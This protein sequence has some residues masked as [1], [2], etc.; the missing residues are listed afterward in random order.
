MTSKQLKLNIK[1]HST[2]SI[3]YACTERSLMHEIKCNNMA[4]DALLI[5][6]LQDKRELETLQQQMDIIKNRIK[7]KQNLLRK[8]RRDVQKQINA[9]TN[10]L[11]LIKKEQNIVKLNKDMLSEQEEILKFQKTS[12]LNLK[13]IQI[14][15]EIIV[16]YIKEFIPYEI[17]YQL[18]DQKFK[19]LKLLNRMSAM[20]LNAII[21]KIRDN[22]IFFETVTTHEANIIVRQRRLGVLGYCICLTIKDA[23]VMVLALIY[24][25][26]KHCPKLALEWLQKLCIL[27]NPKKK[28]TT[29]KKNLITI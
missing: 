16:D 14:L 6:C 11:Q 1:I 27:I 3:D 23:K 25:M 18:L 24:Y 29:S 19:P 28:Y 13:K 5:E 9:A 8:K 15:P 21:Y 26:K 20:S 22:Q 7:Q 17:R 10:I 2:K 12:V 4:R